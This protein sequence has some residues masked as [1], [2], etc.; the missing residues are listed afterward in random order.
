VAHSLQNSKVH[1]K[2]CEQFTVNTANFVSKYTILYF[3]II[4]N[5]IERYYQS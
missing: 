4:K 5:L 1:K 3:H 2:L